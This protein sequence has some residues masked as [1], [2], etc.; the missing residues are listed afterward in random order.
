[1]T[2]LHRTSSGAVSTSG[3]SV[4]GTPAKYWTIFGFALFIYVAS[5]T[6]PFPTVFHKLEFRGNDDFMRLLSV[7]TWLAGQSWFDM[8]QYQFVPPDGLS[9][10]WSRYVDLGI[11]ALQR[12]LALVMPDALAER[13]SIVLWPA[14]L[15]TVFLTL[16]GRFSQKLFSLQAASFS[17]IP[18]AMVPF[19]HSGYFQIGRIDHHNVQMLCMMVLVYAVARNERPLAGGILAGVVA[20]FSLAV[21]LESLL[22]VATAGVTLVILF[23][24]FGQA[25][26]VRL[27]GYGLGLGLAAPVFFAGQTAPADWGM[28]YCDKLSPPILWV[29]TVALCFSV[30]VYIG[31]LRSATPVRRALTV[32]PLGMAALAI[33]WPQITF[34]ASGPY[35][36]L[37]EDLRDT[38]LAAIS[39]TQSSFSVIYNAP[40]KFFLQTFPALSVILAAG[41]ALIRRAGIASN[42]DV[43]R[44]AAVLLTFLSLSFAG[45]FYQVRLAVAVYAVQPLVF[46]FA[47]AALVNRTEVGWPLWHKIVLTMAF[48]GTVFVLQLGV[49][50]KYGGAKL[51]AIA[52]GRET[53]STP[54]R[55]LLD[56]PCRD[57]DALKSLNALPPA[58]ILSS[59]NLGPIL[60]ATT[61]HF[62]LSAPYHRSVEAMRNGF[63]IISAPEKSFL[64]SVPQTGAEYL[65]VCKNSA[66]APDAIATKLAAGETRDWAEPVDLGQS[67]LRLFRLNLPQE[68][69]K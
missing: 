27:L 54:R 16:T 10:H 34:C 19:F 51:S 17:I 29:T 12:T 43:W 46:G 47:L 24:L 38:A 58:R 60:A 7:R 40:E 3:V 36:V 2:A 31:T 69:T 56:R 68:V 53:V 57:S 13:W 22:F 39:E 18:V 42:P 52:A 33:L 62:P 66:Y 55:S 37:P 48:V 45:M 6:I 67:P 25:E 50:T 59:V 8:T 61:H 23:L 65:L 21:G 20:A 4:L 5:Q 32:L 30:L 15:F 1:M 28:A 35:N 11:G 49:V 63:Q 44:S 9:L 26:K 14:L 64:E 41:Y